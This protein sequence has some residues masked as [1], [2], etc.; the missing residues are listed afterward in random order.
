MVPMVTPESAKSQRGETDGNFFIWKINLIR[1]SF[2]FGECYLS[3][4]HPPP[5]ERR[6][7]RRREWVGWHMRQKLSCIV[8]AC[9]KRAA[10]K[11]IIIDSDVTGEQK[12]GASARGSPSKLISKMSSDNRAICAPCVQNS[13]ANY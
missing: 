6:I 1:E 8:S 5:Q 9:G 3:P 2:C 10:T 13:S 11:A 12:S 4:P 7:V